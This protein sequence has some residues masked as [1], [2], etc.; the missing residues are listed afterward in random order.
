M[1][2]LIDSLSHI[3][4]IYFYSASSSLLLLRGAPDTARILFRSFTPKRH[5][6]LQVKDLP[7]VPKWRLERESNPWPFGRKVTNLQGC[8]DP[9]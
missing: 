4:S 3:Q 9:F 8:R 6:Q 1:I 7:K 5:G 2:G